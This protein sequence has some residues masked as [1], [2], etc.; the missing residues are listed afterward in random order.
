MTGEQ[1]ARRLGTNKQRISRMEQDES[2][3]RLTLHT[4]RK[5]AAALDCT[6]VYGLV[7]KQSLEKTITNQAKIVARKRLQRSNQMMRL[8]KQELSQAEKER[9]FLDLVQDIVDEMPK[10]LWEDR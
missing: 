10:A 7:P 6:L 5:A 3:G 9:I 2:H 8:E 1:L 4:L